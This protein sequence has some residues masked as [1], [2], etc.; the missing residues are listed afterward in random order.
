M[1]DGRDPRDRVSFHSIRHSVATALAGKLDIRNLM[2]VMGWK[3][4]S[5][6]ARFVHSN[7]DTKRAA[8]DALEN[9]LTPLKKDKDIA[10]PS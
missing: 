10:F 4:I 1:N 5:M 2:D 9:T 6:A 7:E 8:L 3:Q